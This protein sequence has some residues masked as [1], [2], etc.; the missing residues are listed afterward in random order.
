MNNITTGYFLT[1]FDEFKS[2]PAPKIETFI[3]IAT[4][5]VP[6]SVWGNNTAYATAL[7]A[8][9]MIASTGGSGGMGGAA[10]G[11]LTSETVGDLSRGYSPVGE[12]GSGDAELRTTRYGIEFVALRRETV[13]ACAVTG[14]D[15][16]LPP[17]CGAI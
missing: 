1:L 2:V 11:I 15:T 6:S 14:P 3:G 16:I 12:Q 5:R 17:Y 13:V 4:G 10:G 8:A 7:L 9:H